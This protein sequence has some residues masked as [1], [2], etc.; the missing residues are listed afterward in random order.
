MFKGANNNSVKIKY[1]IILKESKSI[2][3]KE[4]TKCPREKG[5]KTGPSSLQWIWADKSQFKSPANEKCLYL[6]A[7]GLERV[8][9]LF[10]LFI[11]KELQIETEG[12]PE[13]PAIW[14]A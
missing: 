12:S 6:L 1:S 13:I 10:Y 2:H 3:L 14:Q 5:N 7:V 4:E 9:P 8:W 11:Y